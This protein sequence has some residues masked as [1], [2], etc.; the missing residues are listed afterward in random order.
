[1]KEGRGKGAYHTRTRGQAATPGLGGV[2]TTT[3]TIRDTGCSAFTTKILSKKLRDFN[4]NKEEKENNERKT[5]EK[6]LEIIVGAQS[7]Q[8]GV[9]IISRSL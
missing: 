4:K 8:V 3:T 5:L 2:F 9:E 7:I 6:I 1:M